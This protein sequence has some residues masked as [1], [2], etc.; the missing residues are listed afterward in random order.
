MAEP[1]QSAA[2]GMIDSDEAEDKL[3]DFSSEELAT[4]G[5][6]EIPHETPTLDY[7]GGKIDNIWYLDIRFNHVS[8]EPEHNV[9]LYAVKTDKVLPLAWPLRRRGS[10]KLPGMTFFPNTLEE[11]VPVI[12]RRLL[13]N[14]LLGRAGFKP[15]TPW[16][17]TT[18][19]EPLATALSS[20]F[21]RLGL[22]PS[23]GLCSIGVAEEA[24]YLRCQE[25]YVA[26]FQDFAQR[27]LPG[28]PK[29]IIGNH[30]D[31]DFG[32]KAQ[33]M[34]PIPD[35]SSKLNP[36]ERLDNMVKQYCALLKRAE[37]PQGPEIY[38][39][40]EINAENRK[41]AVLVYLSLA[42]KPERALVLLTKQGDADSC[43]EYA[44]RFDFT[45]LLLILT[46]H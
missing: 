37:P 8:K 30:P 21:K 35:D 5:V 42:Q 36:T 11:A 13:I 18:R 9:V 26:S 46:S 17:I 40:Q 32:L 38:I 45:P 39:P 7:E 28:I 41:R 29:G 24:V 27:Y 25:L 1:D 14:L 12:A 16:K 44:A 3:V 4:E 10:E 15:F 22:R 31:E 34:P 20:Y 43:L 2:K 33:P 19:H 6:N 23:C